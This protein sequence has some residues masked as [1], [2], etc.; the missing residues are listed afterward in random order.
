MPQPID[1]VTKTVVFSVDMT[2]WLDEAGATGMPLFSLA[3]ND[4]V[5]VRGG[6]N[7]WNADPPE[8]SV[9]VRQP[10]TNIFTLPVTITNYPETTIEYKF[11][12]NHSAESLALLEGQYVDL[13]TMSISVG[14]IPRGLAA[15]TVHSL[16]VPLKM[17]RSCSCLWRVILIFPTVLLYLRYRDQP[18]FHC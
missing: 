9:M 6:F 14:K 11:F 2:E 13:S 15:P 10:G 4:E 5:Q 3:R 1:P 12:M 8:E 16:W 7:G 17:V 18:D